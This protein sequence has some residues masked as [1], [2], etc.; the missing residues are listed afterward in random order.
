MAFRFRLDTPDLPREFERSAEI[1]REEAERAAALAGVE[2]RN[3]LVSA[4]P[5][6]GTALLRNSWVSARPEARAGIVEISV[7]STAAHALP[8]EEG[9][10][11]HF[12]PP[13]ALGQWIR[14]KLGITDPTRARRAAFRIG[15]AIA[16]RGLPVRRV[17]ARA[18][19]A[20]APG[21]D[22]LFELMADRIQDRLMG[23]A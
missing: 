7:A 21:I 5:V 11:P 3:A 23:G 18:V 8:V 16:R 14:R 6:G 12:P 1:V 17:F 9:A 15:R 19:E 13:L 10:R 4:S 2:L 22:R 20:V